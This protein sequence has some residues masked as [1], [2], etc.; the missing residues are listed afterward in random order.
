M[1]IDDTITAIS[2]PIGHS[3]IGIVRL[4]GR[5]SI[6]IA[7]KIFASHK[8]KTLKK[9]PTHRLVYGHIISSHKEIIDEALVSVMKAPHT[10]TKENIVE[11]NCHG[12]PVPLRRILALVLKNGARLAEPGEFTRRAF[13]N[14][15]IDLAQAEAVLDVINSLT[16]QSRKTAFEQLSGGLSK[17]TESIR[18]GLLSII[19]IVEAYIDFPEE[20][21][22]FPALK[23][24]KKT[25]LSIRKSLRQLIES[26]QYGMILRD[27]LKTA[28]I[29][30]PNVGKSSLLNALLEQ[31][32]AIVTEVPGTT[33]DIIEDYLNIHGLP[34]KIMDTAGI[35]KVEDIAEKEGVKRSHKA[36][37]D[38][39]LVLIVLDG[40]ESLHDTD[41]ELIDKANPENTILVINK[42][43]LQ[44][45]IKLDKKNPPSPPLLKGGKGGFD[46]I[47]KIS[48]LKGKGIDELKNKIED[49]A[50]H[51]RPAN[52]AVTV[53]NIRHVHVL[54]RTLKSVDSFIKEIDK[55]TSPE[56]LSV[57]LREALDA[58]GEITGATTSEDILN[59]IF[60]NFCI[61]K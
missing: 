53:T 21:I 57:E 20:E 58:I 11:I 4:S 10:Y 61:G 33:R 6:K 22:E 59:K 32:R 49:V 13:L 18:E 35:R 42:I 23:E 60:T 56:F 19:A 28:I 16:E 8:K 27:G 24:M 48:A 44:Q 7:D 5:D 45:K 30:R 39:D 17:K 36:M 46:A 26:S 47:A 29:G 25:A 41:K 40:S 43:D 37:K 31:D 1:F 34:V 9:T 14:G 3:G 2:T 52:A 15:R 51:G 38:A 12:G 54:K 50:L 55:K